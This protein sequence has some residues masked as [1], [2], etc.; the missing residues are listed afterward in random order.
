MRA[1]HSGIERKIVF[2]VVAAV[3]H[4]VYGKAAAPDRALVYI[5]CSPSPPPPPCSLSSA[6]GRGRR[7][8][9]A[10]SRS[11]DNWIVTAAA[12]FGAKVPPPTLS[13]EGLAERNE[14][15]E[16]SSISSSTL[17]RL[18]DKLCLSKRTLR[19]KVTT[20]KEKKS[21]R[22]YFYRDQKRSLLS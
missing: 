17:L 22:V 20:Q 14:E 4:L 2:V 1:I 16:R 18:L 21:E 19:L 12:W 3:L 6:K 8:N 13:S 11:Y 9:E 7:R 15:R 5:C 10:S